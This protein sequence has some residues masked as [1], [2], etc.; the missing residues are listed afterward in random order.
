MGH[1]VHSPT[2]YP[3]DLYSLYRN[4]MYRYMITDIFAVRS[5]V[6]SFHKFPVFKMS[7]HCDFHWSACQV[8][9]TLKTNYYH[10]LDKSLNNVLNQC[11]GEHTCSLLSVCY[12]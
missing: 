4:T 6:L 7:R 12:V 10:K 5:G 11:G 9:C 1:V 2:R 3:V 8:N